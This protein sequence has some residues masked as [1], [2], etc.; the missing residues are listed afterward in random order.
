MSDS[1]TGTGLGT[2]AWENREWIERRL[3]AL[4]RWFKSKK[5]GVIILGP[6]GTGK[7]ILGRILSG[8]FDS[9]LALPGRYQASI[10][11]ERYT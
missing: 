11:T 5:S 6:G 8:Q 7:T 4:F 2:W 10:A 1:V 3:A 9:V